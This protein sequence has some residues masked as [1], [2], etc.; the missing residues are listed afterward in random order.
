MKKLFALVLA[1]VLCTALMSF[2]Q[3]EDPIKVGIINLDPAESGYR[4]AN[5]NLIPC[6]SHGE[7]S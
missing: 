7:R 6:Q 1:L 5:V 3:A 2:A 4:E